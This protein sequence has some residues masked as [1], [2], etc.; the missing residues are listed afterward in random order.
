M[1]NL[2]GAELFTK[3]K[4]KLA[5]LPEGHRTAATA[6]LYGFLCHFALDSTCHGLI[7]QTVTEKKPFWKKLLHLE[8]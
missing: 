1:H 5:R 6:Y 3:M 4:E 7:E 8:S 2:S